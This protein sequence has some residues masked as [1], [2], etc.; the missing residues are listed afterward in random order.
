MNL[1]VPIL[2]ALAITHAS[3]L[4]STTNSSDEL[5]DTSAL[6]YICVNHSSAT[7]STFSIAASTLKQKSFSSASK[8]S[9]RSTSYSSSWFTFSLLLLAGDLEVNPGP[10]Y[11]YPCGSCFRPCKINQQS[12]QCDS[13]DSWY[14]RKCVQLSEEMFNSLANSSVSWI[15]CQ[16]GLPNFSSTLFNSSISQTDNSFDPLRSP[17]PSPTPRFRP[18]ISSTPKAPARHFQ[19]SPSQIPNDRNNSSK[20]KNMGTNRSPSPSRNNI[21]SLL[22]NFRSLPNKKDFVTGLLSAHSESRN[23]DIIFGTE[24]WLNDSILNSELNLSDY[25]IHRRDREDRQGGGVFLCVKKSLNSTLVAKGKHSETVFAKI[26]V[27]GKP[28]VI[29]ACAYRAPDLSF[30]QCKI[31]CDEISEVKNKFRNSLFWLAGDFNI[32]DIDWTTHKIADVHTYSEPINQLFLDLAY[33]HGLHQTVRHPTR[34]DNILDLFFTNNISLVKN[35]EVVSGVSDHDAAI[36]DSRLQLLHQ[37]QPKRKI[38]LWN[39]ANIDQIKR[40]ADAF[41]NLFIDTHKDLGVNDMWLFIKKNLLTILENNVP[42]KTS[43][44]K[45]W[46]PWISTTTKRLI[47]NKNIWYK[48]A[49]ARNDEKTWK[50][51]KE[52]KRVA[53]KECRKSHE[54]YV[55]D[56]ITEDNSNK[57]FWTYIKTQRQEKAGVSDLIKDNHLITDPEGKANVLNEQFCKVFSTPDPIPSGATTCTTDDPPHNELHTIH[58]AKQG[59]L[60][61]LLNINE[62]KATGPDDIPGKLLKI[63]AHELHEIFTI[64]FQTSLNQG[65][66]PDDWKHAI[67]HPLFKKGDKTNSENYRPLSMTCIPCK[68]QEHI[69]HSTIMGFLDHNNLLTDTQHGFRKNRSCETQLITTVRDFANCLNTSSQVDAVLLDFSKAFDKVDHR[70]LLKKM[71]KLG[72][73]GDILAWT[74]S[75]LHMR[76]QQVLVDGSFSNS[77]PVL[78]GVPQGT[79][80]GPLLFLIYINDIHKDLSPGTFIRL[81]ADDSLLYR[82]IR[83]VADTIT[84]QR[85]LDILQQWEISNKMQFHPDKCQILQITNKRNPINS[86]YYIHGTSLKL[87]DSAKYLGITIDSKLS[88]DPHCKNTYNKASFMLS[89]LERN[90]KKCPPHIK[91]KCFNAL[92]RPILE[93]SC[94]VWDPYKSTQIDRLEKLNKRAARFITGNHVL[95]HGNTKKNMTTLGWPPLQE[96][97]AQIK[98]QTFYKIKNNIIHVPLDDLSPLHTPR[99]P[100]NYFVPR[101]TVDAHLHSFFPSSIRLWN[102]LPEP[103][104]S[105]D[106]VN[107]FKSSISN[108]NICSSY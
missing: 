94:S 19:M 31:L 92:V 2:L 78:S 100:F 35:T 74:S 12:I 11:K 39:K 26:N 10:N 76:T 67:I 25:N 68:L 70:L 93:Y 65:I 5:S 85:D 56:L 86:T 80:L 14:H 42:S 101:S 69:I 53:Q 105:S 98:L 54:E 4:F 21:S 15:C 34:G 28:P 77:S 63:C 107:T 79:V 82:I 45:F 30:D 7:N 91:L 17:P 104:K 41:K 3:N 88:W 32:P 61:L 103:I 90:L 1:L 57:K 71:E 72:I 52:I 95:E 62:N 9:E 99:R 44:S 13:C 97:R 48:K 6:S 66:V 29:L 81:F 23:I 84:L 59:V 51:Y 38:R 43:S 89:F 37:K 55:K 16:C 108:V 58:I 75:F 8:L 96:R 20:N 106:S 102:S 49:K 18:G 83:T 87:F 27:R 46:L 73:K 47:R 64:L 60:K 36:V 22:I 40:D 24:T 50:K 33:D